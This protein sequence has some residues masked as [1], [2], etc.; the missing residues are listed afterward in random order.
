VVKLLH[1]VGRPTSI[2]TT[3]HG[4]H[5]ATTVAAVPTEAQR[6]DVFDCHQHVGMFGNGNPLGLSEPP[7]SPIDEKS[8]RLRIMK[9]GGVRQAAVIVTPTYLRPD[10]LADTRRVNNEIAS[11][12]DTNPDTFPIAIG[13][14]EPLYGERGLA[15]IE[16]CARELR[17][18]GISFHAR[19]QGVSTDDPW[20]RH[21]VNK[22]AEL[23]MVPV[24]HSFGEAADEALW[25]VALHGEALPDTPILVLD[26]FGTLESTKEMMSSVADRCPNLLFDTANA[27]HVFLLQLFA[28]R[29]GANRVLFGSDLYSPPLGR[30]IGRVL[31][32]VLESDLSDDDKALIVGGNARRLFGV[33]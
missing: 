30:S 32:E 4:D 31:D 26:A 15:E 20:V 9:E 2:T 29:F 12:R 24:I 19:F 13:V 11:Y 16:R 5:R 8:A 14:V 21:Y 7:V 3:L 10:G 18:A 22:I 17:L 27:N 28:R 23:G 33:G 1:L 6:F 25:K